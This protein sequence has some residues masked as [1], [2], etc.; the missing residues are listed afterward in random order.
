[1]TLTIGHL[2]VIAKLKFKGYMIKLYYK[3]MMYLYTD[4]AFTKSIVQITLITIKFLPETDHNK[5]IKWRHYYPFPLATG[6][7]HEKHKREYNMTIIINLI[8]DTSVW[9]YVFTWGYY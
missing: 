4:S 7:Y 8:K 1:M 3:N 2:N 6:Y 5:L 9:M